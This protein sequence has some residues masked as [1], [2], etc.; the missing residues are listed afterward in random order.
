MIEYEFKANYI[1]LES[2]V[3]HK[4]FILRQIGLLKL[5]HEIAA[6][7]SLLIRD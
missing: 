2:L 3:K 6:I 4:G 5:I 7:R 1:Y